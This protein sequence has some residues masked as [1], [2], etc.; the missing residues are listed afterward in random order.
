[1]NSPPTP[2]SFRSRFNRARVLSVEWSSPN[3]NPFLG[4]TRRI[5]ARGVRW[6]FTLIFIVIIWLATMGVVLFWA[7]ET[8]RGRNWADTG[9]LLWIGIVWVITW[10]T[11]SMRDNELL[12]QEVIKGRFEPL[13][14]LPLSSTKRAWLWSAPNSLWGLLLCATMLPAIAWGLGGGLFEWREAGLLITVVMFSLWSTPSWSPV[15]WRVQGARPASTGKDAFKLTSANRTQ[16]KIGDGLVLPPDLAVNARGWSGGIGL[17]APIWSITQSS[18]AGVTIGVA[19]AYW[20]GLPPHVRAASNEI[21]FNWPLFLVR[22][23]GEAQPFFGFALAPIMIFSPIWLAGATIRVLR[24]AAVTGREPFWTDAH[25]ALWKRAQTVHGGLGFLFLLG[26]LWPSAIEG[27]WLAVWF[28]KLVGTP[29]QALAAWWVMAVA[30]GA[31]ATTAM[32]RAALE[33]PVGELT[34]RAQLPRAAK[35]AVRGLGIALAFWAISCLLGWRSPFSALWLQILPATLAM[36]AVWVTAQCASHAAQRA[37]R[38][39]NA[40]ATWHFIW[41]YGG[42][43]GGALLLVLAQFPARSLVVFYPLSPWTLWLMLR[44]PHVG[45]NSIFWIACGAHGLLA[46]ITGALAWRLGRDRITATAAA[47]TTASA[48]GNEALLDE[49]T[50]QTQPANAPALPKTAQTVSLT[51]RPLSMPDQWTARLLAWLGRFDNPVLTLEMRRAITGNPKE[52]ARGLLFIQALVASPPLIILPLINVATGYWADD[53]FTLFV[54]LMLLIPCAAMLLGTSSVSLCYDRD[55]LDGTL[56]LLFLTPRTSEEI[57]LGKAGP[58]AVRSALLGIACLSVFLV[59]ALMLPT[60][61]Q[62]LMSAAYVGAPLW[63]GAFTLRGIVGSH[64]MALKKRKIGVT[65]VSFVTSLV[66]AFGLLA[67]AGVVIGAFSMG[68]PYIIAAALLLA[69]IY[70]V[71]TAWLWKRGVAALEYWRLNGAP[72]AK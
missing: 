10:L 3:L 29:S 52:L 8:R 18:M 32:W 60:A 68:A 37:P 59:G 39:Y 50:P 67:E 63:I 24:L 22:W 53:A 44:D 15:A 49:L 25:F 27:Q 43:I 40:L 47:T 19:R 13:Q 64:W 23:L 16:S 57:A 35:L 14:L 46:L 72:G 42:P 69:L 4:Q 51:R 5:D 20:L 54:G 41:F 38:F 65:D 1:M 9:A 7:N 36:A 31:L 12:R 28:G 6:V 26:V 66:I 62:S 61:G 45:A 11:K 48:Q 2:P 55:R 17:A 33:L 58:F 71:E 56:E 21:W 34:L 30:A 70:I